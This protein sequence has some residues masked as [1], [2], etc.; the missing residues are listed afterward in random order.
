MSSIV[1]QNRPIKI[2]MVLDQPFPPDARVER[3]AV[4]LVQAG[5]QVHLLC[6][7][8][9]ATES[10]DSVYRG[11]YIHR[12]SPAE[13]TTKWLGLTHRLP[14]KGLYK[15]WQWN[16][17]HIDTAWHALIK[18]FAQ[19]LELDALHIHD[20]KLLS[21]GQSVGQQLTIPVVADLHENYPALMGMM[22]G[23]NADG[24]LNKAKSRRA[25]AQWDTIEKLACWQADKILVVTEEATER[26]AA[27]GINPAKIT[28]IPNAVDMDKFAQVAMDPNVQRHYKHQFLLT[29]VGH[30]NGP[31]RGIET[32]FEALALLKD[33][34]PNLK[35]VAAGA[36]R[37]GY[38]QQLK[39]MA[40]RLQIAHLVD[41]TGWLDEAAFG[42]YI[43]SADICLCP[44]VAN[45]H[46]HATFPNKVYLYHWY[47][48]PVISSDCRPLARYMDSTQGGLTFASGNAQALAGHIMHLYQHPDL[49]K[50]LGEN[51]HQA[52]WHHHNW[53]RHAERLCQ[54]YADLFA[55]VDPLE[56]L[57]N[58]HNPSFAHALDHNKDSHSVS[59]TVS[60]VP[61]VDDLSGFTP[62]GGGA[63]VSGRP[64]PVA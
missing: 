39:A 10:A 29:Y 21:T 27:K 6:G 51:G 23:K 49:R 36:V 62:I 28:V 58:P 57:P 12:V 53:Q 40:T 22:K 7:A 4:T 43:N 41:W 16:A 14:Y 25:Q 33:T 17:F 59:H 38:A 63:S 54:V 31:H 9:A 15:I 44:H 34:I 50:Q 2:G 26:L 55:D 37:E 60:P 42:S 13:V 19:R 18:R 5:Y 61:P 45:D 20:L 48:K 64:F 35:F 46:T 30:V 1:V 24:S 56:G 32:V 11:I 8:S 47:A 52:V 3:E